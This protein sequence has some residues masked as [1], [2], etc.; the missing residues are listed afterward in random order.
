[1]TSH[2]TYLGAKSSQIANFEK[3]Y[4]QPQPN[5]EEYSFLTPFERRTESMDLESEAEIRACLENYMNTYLLS[6]ASS[7]YHALHSLFTKSIRDDKL[8][9]KPYSNYDE[10]PSFE[11]TTL[12]LEKSGDNHD[13]RPTTIKF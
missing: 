11:R 1:L 9:R 7:Q 12:H 2:T 4:N 5:I 8:I 3:I 13:L 6:S 10:I